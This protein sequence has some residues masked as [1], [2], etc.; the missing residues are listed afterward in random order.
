M[1][2]LATN[3][4]TDASGG[5]TATINSYTPTE[6]NMAGRNRIINGDM[7]IDQRNAGA[8]SSTGAS[9]IGYVTVDRWAIGANEN[10]GTIQ[11]VSDAPVGFVQ[12]TK[13]TVTGTTTAG[14]NNYGTFCQRVEGN[15]IADFGWGTSS[16]KT[17][18]ISFWVKASISGTY[19]GYVYNNSYNY[20]FNFSYS[21]NSTNTWEYKTITIIAP[22]TGSF[23]TGT[24]YGVEV[25]FVLYAGSAY[26]GTANTWNAANYIVAPT[27][28]ITYPFQNNGMT[29]QWTGVQLEAGSVATPFEHRMY[30]QELALCQRYYQK[31]S[32]SSG[33]GYQIYATGT[34]ES[35]ATLW[36]NV[37]LKVTMRAQPTF[38][39]NGSIATSYGTAGTLVT[40]TNQTGPDIGV[41][42]WTNGSGGLAGSATFVR[43]N[44]NTAGFISFIAEL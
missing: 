40:D 39:S 34:Y 9:F 24:S 32:A 26:R 11:Q 13:I 28:S 38:A 44:A 14:A 20:C 35:A 22:T 10:L 42:G 15:N 17:A 36:V 41:F 37:P 6:S 21:V 29:I 1:S 2:T 8:S 7:R 4:I 3:A 23:P 27:G 16:A 5:N 33:G 31:I 19:A 12:S 25:G 43:S 18:T 30:G